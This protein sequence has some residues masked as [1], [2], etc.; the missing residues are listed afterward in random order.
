MTDSQRERTRRSFSEERTREAEAL[1]QGSGVS[2]EQVSTE[3]S[4]STSIMY[5]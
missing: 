4:L 3:L 1:F 2:A 5:R